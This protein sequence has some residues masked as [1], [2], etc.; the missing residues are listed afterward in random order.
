MLPDSPKPDSSSCAS[1]SPTPIHN[2]NTHQSPSHQPH[3]SQNNPWTPSSTKPAQSTKAKSYASPPSPKPT[4]LTTWPPSQQDFEGQRLAEYITYG[5]LSLTGAIAFLVG[6]FAQDIYLTLYIG[7]GGTA[8]AFLVVVPQW[9]FY[10][11]HPQPFL[12]P[13]T[14]AGYIS[15]I[16]IE[17]DGKKVS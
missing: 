5:L 3:S 9:P 6:F 1:I 4:K 10:N 17:V 7:L 11:K 8:L 14:T 2:H 13:R 16:N 15:G 12:P